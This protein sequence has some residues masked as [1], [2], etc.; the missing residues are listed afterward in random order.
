MRGKKERPNKIHDLYPFIQLIYNVQYVFCAF[1][2]LIIQVE[3]STCL[4]E[5]ICP[6]YFICCSGVVVVYVKCCMREKDRER[7]NVMCSLCILISINF[8]L[9]HHRFIHQ[10][11]QLNILYLICIFI[12]FSHSHHQLKCVCV[13]LSLFLYLFLFFFSFAFN[14][15]IRYIRYLDTN[16]FK[17][18]RL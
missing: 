3:V 13:S 15:F 14:L 1:K 6:V 5:C 12:I 18:A 9:F 11:V 7:K 10:S 17:L 4:C 8:V 2:K 16:S